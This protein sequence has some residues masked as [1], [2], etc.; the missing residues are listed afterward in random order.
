MQAA[1][2]SWSQRLREVAANF[3]LM[4]FFWLCENAQRLAM[5]SRPAFCVL[6][7][8]FSPAIRRGARSNARFLLGPHSTRYQ[9]ARLLYRRLGSF[10]LFCFDV[11]CSR[12][13][14]ME[15]MRLRVQ[16]IGGRE[17]YRK[18]RAA[19]CGMIVVTAHM[20]SFEL[21]MAELRAVE[22]HVHV[23]FRRD[24][25][26]LFERQRRELRRRL[27]IHEAALDDGWT[28]WIKLREALLNNH[29]VVIQGD[30]VLPGQKGKC[31]PLMGGQMELPLA[32]IK[33]AMATGAPIVPIFSL[34]A[35][36]GRIQLLV[37]E[38]VIVS[39]GEDVSRPLLHWAGILERQ[40]AD[41]PDQWLMLQ[42]AWHSD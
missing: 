22:E 35:P 27:G 31:A 41:Y 10:Y 16:W 4:I 3:W 7:M 40:I 25:V 26:G 37:N 38:P 12:R 36:D 8:V 6:A 34:R 9:R 33:L 14:T 1:N 17:I 29:V 39:A 5:A 30:R 2:P 32:P 42:P 11:A 20:G 23:L 24:A 15:Q 13:C 21:A 18:A 28:V 19:H